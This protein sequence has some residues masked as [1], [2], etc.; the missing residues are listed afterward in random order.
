VLAAGLERYRDLVTRWAPALDLVSGASGGADLG[1][2]LTE[3]LAALPHLPPAGTLLDVGSGVG[4]PVVPLLLARPD[5]PAVLLEPRERR[6]AF[7]REVIR[8]LGLP[9]EVLRQRF[10]DQ[11]DQ[12]Y[13]AITVRGVDPRAW[14]RNA[15]S[16][17]T[18]TG[19][20]LWWT[21]AEKAR[22]FAAASPGGRVL[23]F[24]LPDP[25]RV[26]LVVWHPRST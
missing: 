6:W 15:A 19:R 7:L 2:L 4:I 12:Q 13:S 20:V 14:Q 8:D 23:T 18:A 22:L 11:G 24:P 1:R 17:L 25:A 26:T 9:A 21:A 3:S 10:Q 16:H 5:L